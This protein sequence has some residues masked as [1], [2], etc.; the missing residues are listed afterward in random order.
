MPDHRQCRSPA[1]Y[2]EC[3]HAVLSAMLAAPHG[4]FESSVHVSGW[5]VAYGDSY[6][7][8]NSHIH[9]Y[10]DSY[11]YAYR[12]GN[13]ND[14]TCSHAYSYRDAYGYCVA[15]VRAHAQAASH[16]WA[17]ALKTVVAGVVDPGPKGHAI[18]YRL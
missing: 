14:Y 12:N 7:D 3:L 2:R 1:R 8:T 9:A 5:P 10:A 6:S 11:T 13:S 15:E 16:A 18:S 17:A 4:R